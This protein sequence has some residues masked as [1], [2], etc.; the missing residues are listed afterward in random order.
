[1]AFAFCRAVEHAQQRELAADGLAGARGRGHQR[2]VVGVVQRT[3]ALRLD[4]VEAREPPACAGG[5]HQI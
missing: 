1:M 3:E 2:V 4:G 5:A